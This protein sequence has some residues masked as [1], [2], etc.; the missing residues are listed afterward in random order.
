MTILDTILER[1]REEVAALRAERSAAD[2]DR[3][4][5]SVERTPL[6]LAAALRSLD[7]LTVIAEAKRR[8]P[9]RGLLAAD[10]DPVRLATAYERGGAAAI[11][12]LTDRDFF[13][14]SNDDLQS[15]RQSVAL[16]ILR[17]DFTIDWV[18]IAQSRAIG[19]D[20]V[21]LIVAALGD[22]QLAELHDAATGYGLSV[23]VECH[24]AAEVERALRISP[25]IVGI[26]NRDLHGF[27][28]SLQTSIDLR[29]QIPPEIVAVSE[30][31]IGGADD[32]RRL[33]SAG[34][35]AILVGERLVTAADPAAALHA[36]VGS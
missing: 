1:K 18:Q 22:D 28:V 10:F 24:T 5:R 34:F 26:N 29:Q 36:L 14:G 19:A 20:A 17:K 27:G 3:A 32:A 8:S 16:P 4:A 15:V 31:G 35:D 25:S 6:N 13:G 21:L 30:S 33:R 7:K 23:L 12:V 9:S 11:S 2:W